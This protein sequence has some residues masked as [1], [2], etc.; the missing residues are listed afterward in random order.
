MRFQYDQTCSQEMH[1]AP[2][3]PRN[4]RVV[5]NIDYAAMRYLN[6]GAPEVHQV[7]DV[8]LA[9][10]YVGSNG[11]RTNLRLFAQER[12]MVEPAC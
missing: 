10:G 11:S 9:G 12:R 8:L 2:E 3:D 7:G 5:D 4:G 1:L 6:G